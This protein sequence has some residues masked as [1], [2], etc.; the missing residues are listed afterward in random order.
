[1]IMKTSYNL[2]SW[3]MVFEVNLGLC[4][5]GMVTHIWFQNKLNFTHYGVI[6]IFLHGYL[7]FDYIFTGKLK[8]KTYILS[9]SRD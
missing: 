3:N 2:L 1:M 8:L 6:A 7:C 5:Q 9:H 4:S